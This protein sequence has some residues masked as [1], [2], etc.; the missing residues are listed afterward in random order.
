MKQ[1]K[2]TAKQNRGKVQNLKKVKN[3]IITN[4]SQKGNHPKHH[5]VKKRKFIQPENLEELGRTLGVD[6]YRHGFILIN[7]NLLCS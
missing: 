3:Q 5:Q 1:E 4:N 6:L 7:P 2:N